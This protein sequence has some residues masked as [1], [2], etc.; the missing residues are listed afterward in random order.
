MELFV[1]KVNLLKTLALAKARRD[2]SVEGVVPQTKDSESGTCRE[3]RWDV[4]FQTVHAEVEVGESA[5]EAE[6]GR[7]AAVEA[8]V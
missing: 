8:V 3:F 1:A 2:P 5:Q 4:T 7:Y 6:L